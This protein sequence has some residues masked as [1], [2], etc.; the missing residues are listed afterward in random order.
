MDEGGW[1]VASCPLFKTFRNTKIIKGIHKILWL[2]SR[3]LLILMFIG[4]IRGQVIF[5]GKGTSMVGVSSRNY[6]KTPGVA[7]C[8]ICI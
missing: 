3:S 2:T 8:C 1:L 7:S 6:F 5:S 4:N